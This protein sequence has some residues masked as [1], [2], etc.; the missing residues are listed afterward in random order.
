[1]NTQFPEKETN[2]TWDWTLLGFFSP[3]LL[4]SQFIEVSRGGRWWITYG[5]LVWVRP[6]DN[7]A[8][9]IQVSTAWAQSYG[10]KRNYKRVRKCGLAVYPGR[11]WISL[12][13]TEQYCCHIHSSLWQISVPL[14][15]P[16]SFPK[17]QW[18]S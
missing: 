4:M 7:S 12:L 18:S 15:L 13:N 9:S 8:T 1:M 16:N 17:S 3:S 10:T 6:R 5:R 14:I 2:C 11:I